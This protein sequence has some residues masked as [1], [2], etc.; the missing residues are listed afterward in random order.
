[1]LNILQFRLFGYNVFTSLACE[2]YPLQVLAALFKVQICVGNILGTFESP[3]S[4]ATV[5]LK[6]TKQ[7]KIRKT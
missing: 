1:M 6:K 2:Y 7:N 3:S 5:S 4:C